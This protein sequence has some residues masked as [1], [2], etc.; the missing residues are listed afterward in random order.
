MW[1]VIVEAFGSRFEMTEPL[2]DGV[3]QSKRHMPEL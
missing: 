2:L 3:A 1:E